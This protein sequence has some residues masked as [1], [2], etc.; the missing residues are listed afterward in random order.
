[1]LFIAALLSIEIL[2][3]LILKELYY[4]SSRLKFYISLFINLFLSFCIWFLLIRIRNYSGPFDVPGNVRD[5]MYFMGLVS[6]VMV[7]RLILIIF[8]FTGKLFRI[9]KGGFIRW[10]SR[11]GLVISC[12]ICLII[13]SGSFHGRYNFK[14]EEVTATIKN[15]P[16]RLDGLKIVQLSD[17]HLV[18]FYKNHALL[19]ELIEKANS[20]QPDLVIN[21]GDFISYGWREF[22]GCDTILRKAGGRYGSFAIF[23]NHDMGTYYP[24]AGRSNMDINISKMK[25]LMMSS[26][27]QVLFDNNAT[28]DIRGVKVEFI[29]VRTSGRFPDIIHGDLT[30]AME[31]AEA[32]DFKILLC[33][34]PNQWNEDVTGKTDIDLSFSGHTHGMQMGIMTR[35]FRWSPAKYIYPHWAGLYAEKDQLLY[36]N[37]GLGVLAIPFR[38]W[39]PPEITVMTLKAD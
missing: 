25:E 30:K 5:R 9:R 36:V 23:G 3:F 38:I 15:L 8:H 28:I 11:T 2:I 21:T 31:G 35:K 32:A 7:P 34:D 13:A 6:G 24:G 39:M 33:H 26:G 22:D 19:Q 12:L 14:T 20:F 37:R 4:N 16:P 10:L 29:G 18:S 1:M 27:Y 17:M